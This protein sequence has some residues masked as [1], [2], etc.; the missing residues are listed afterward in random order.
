MNQGE[1]LSRVKHLNP[2]SVAKQRNKDEIEQRRSVEAQLKN[3]EDLLKEKSRELEDKVDD[4]ADM[5]KRWKQA[6]VELDKLK[7]WQ[8]RLPYQMTDGELENE[9]MQLRYNIRN[10]AFQYFGDEL[11]GRL[12][13]K[14]P[15]L[16]E[17][18]SELVSNKRVLL[19]YLLSSGKRAFIIQAYMWK[20]LYIRLFDT[21]IWAGHGRR[22]IWYLNN[23]MDPSMFP[24]PFIDFFNIV[25]LTNS[26]KER[27]DQ[28][29]SIQAYRK[30]QL[31]S[32][33]TTEMALESIASSEDAES[34][35][36][37]QIS[38]FCNDIWLDVQQFTTSS[39]S[40]IQTEVLKILR[41]AVDIDQKI[42]RQAARVNWWY[43]EPQTKFK[44]HEMSLVSGEANIENQS[45][46]LVV[47]P[48][49]TK[50]GKSIGVDFDNE[51]LLVPPEV[52]L[53]PHHHVAGP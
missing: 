50:R 37:D 6:A 12:L 24:L 31:W 43:C 29:I 22:A 35:L 8:N 36:H 10:F 33:E 16:L 7:S 45:V 26:P 32:A 52:S 11:P 53:T 3:M 19:D 42:R 41:R 48:G 5:R 40:D 23:E 9:V 34:M 49:L 15:Q 30:F 28:D 17:P 51:I 44:P 18:F 25:L 27:Q 39:D 1:E 46:S 14:N 21:F 13:E 4:L 47:A 20:F 2:M 38:S